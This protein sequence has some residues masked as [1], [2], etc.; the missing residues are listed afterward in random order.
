MDSDCVGVG[1]V[2]GA[3]S[4]M[5]KMCV[6]TLAMS[7]G[8]LLE[9]PHGQVESECSRDIDKHCQTLILKYRGARKLTGDSLKVVWAKFSTLG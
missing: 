6:R 7:V 4:E 3:S 1:T 5:E 2:V 9:R 8:T